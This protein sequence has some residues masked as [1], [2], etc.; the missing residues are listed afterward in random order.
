MLLSF[1]IFLALD[2][3]AV[4]MPLACTR[5]EVIIFQKLT[6]YYLSHLGV[7]LNARS[8]T[9]SRWKVRLTLS[10]ILFYLFA[11]SL[12]LPWLTKSAE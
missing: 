11:L 8:Q 5:G 9:R 10:F 2:I 6:S 7:Q 1:A 3:I 4:P 12:L